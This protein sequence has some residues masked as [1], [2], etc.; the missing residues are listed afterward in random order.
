MID[1]TI[2]VPIIFAL[3]QV[4]KKAGLSSRYAP[5]VSMILG[6]SLFYLFGVG[7]I[8]PKLFSGLIA[9][10]SASGLYSS[11]KTVLK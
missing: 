1:L 2:A 4:F 11:A 6:L 3:V 9:G 7:E 8:L 5:L 10:L